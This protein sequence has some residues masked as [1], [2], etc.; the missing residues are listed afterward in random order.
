MRSETI[1]DRSPVEFGHI[2]ARFANDIGEVVMTREEIKK[3]I[4]EAR[5]EIEQEAGSGQG[6][7]RIRVVG[8][9][10]KPRVVKIKQ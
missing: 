10:T 5:T 9:A 6:N 1:H 4:S 3:A 7:W 8:Q 2:Q